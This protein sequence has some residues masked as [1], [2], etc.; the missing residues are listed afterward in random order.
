[1]TLKA[2]ILS[3]LETVFFDGDE[4]GTVATTSGA[5]EIPG[6]LFNDYYEA[7]P[8]G[9]VG[10]GSAQPVFRAATASATGLSEGDTLTIDGTGYSVVVIKPDDS[11]TKDFQLHLN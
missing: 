10:I 1:M 6:I 4:F 3:E 8:G 2:D 7:E 5:V 9:N 11:G